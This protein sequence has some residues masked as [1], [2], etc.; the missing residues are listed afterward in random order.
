[1]KEV[2]DRVEI[3]VV[4]VDLPAANYGA[5]MNSVNERAGKQGGADIIHAVG[6]VGVGDSD[7]RSHPD[8][9]SLV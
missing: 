5:G 6:A 9:F 3:I 1:M 2:G 4:V 8:H 7:Q